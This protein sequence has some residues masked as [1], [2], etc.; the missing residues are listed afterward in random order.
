MRL[1]FVERHAGDN[2]DVVLLT[3]WKQFVFGSLVENVV[4]DLHAIDDR[5]QR[6]SEARWSAAIGSG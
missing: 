5:P 1:L 3:A 2:G 4:D 6:A